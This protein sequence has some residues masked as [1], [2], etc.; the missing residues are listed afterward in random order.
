MLSEAALSLKFSCLSL[1]NIAVSESNGFLKTNQP[2]H[3]DLRS[4]RTKMHFILTFDLKFISSQIVYEIEMG[5]KKILKSLRFTLTELA[6][7]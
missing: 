1:Q 2:T 4:N 3:A 5:I 6:K 7:L